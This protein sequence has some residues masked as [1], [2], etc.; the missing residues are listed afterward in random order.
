MDSISWLWL[1][2]QSFRGG[3]DSSVRIERQTKGFPECC[4]CAFGGVRFC[5]LDGDIVD[6][7]R[8][9]SSTFTR[10]VAF[11]NGCR[12]TCVHGNPHSGDI[13]GEECAAVFA[14]EDT[15]GFKGLSAP[16]IE[17]ENSISF[18][19]RIPA[20]DIVE[21]TAIRFSSADIAVIEIAPQRLD[22]FC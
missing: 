19:D 2:A 16:P 11:T 22:L 15:A 3:Y 21:R 13:D 12:A 9:R 1:M 20:F 18:R 7:A 5:S 14:G 8:G 10:A 17:S 6:L 4:K